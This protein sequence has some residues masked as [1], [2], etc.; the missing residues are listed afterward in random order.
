[1]PDSGELQLSQDAS[2]TLPPDD[3]RLIIAGLNE[4]PAKHANPVLQ[5]VIA[6]LQASAKQQVVPLA[7]RPKG[8]AA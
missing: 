4:L 3:W 8:S 5:R 2:V 7:T 6:G 1:M